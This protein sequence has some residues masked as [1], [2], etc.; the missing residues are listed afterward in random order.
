MWSGFALPST[1]SRL[2]T[3]SLTPAR[4]GSS[5]IESRRIPSMIER[6]PRAPVLRAIAFWAM[7][8]IAQK[9]IGVDVE[10]LCPPFHDFPI[11]DDLT[12]P[13]QARQLKHRIK[14]ESLN[15][16]AQTTGPRTSGDR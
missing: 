11:D 5:N 14:E 3:I 8:R 15:D 7:P 9:A 2:M 4:L 12:D 13:G 16:R 6:R 10:R 1:T